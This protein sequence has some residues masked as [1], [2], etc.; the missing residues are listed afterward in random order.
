M[1]GLSLPPDMG[2]VYTSQPIR[3]QAKATAT[4]R[5]ARMGIDSNARAR[6]RAITIACGDPSRGLLAFFC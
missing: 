5:R 4:S 2:C 3:A 6:R 1:A